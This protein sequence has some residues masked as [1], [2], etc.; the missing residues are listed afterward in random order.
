MLQ[1]ALFGIHAN[2]RQVELLFEHPHHAVTFF[3]AQ[4]PV[5]D[6]DTVESFADRSMYESSRYGRI[7]PARKRA[8]HMS[9]RSYTLS[10]MRDLLVHDGAHV[11]VRLDPGKIQQKMPEQLLAAF[12]MRDFGMELQGIDF[13][14]WVFHRG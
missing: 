14:L 3:E 7:H 8:D 11:P 9:L 2:H 12:G 4:K 10:N 1:K 6:K 13:L 5:I